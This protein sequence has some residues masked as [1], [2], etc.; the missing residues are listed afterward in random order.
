MRPLTITGN[1]FVIYKA[2]SSS[3]LIFTLD[4]PDTLTCI[5]IVTSNNYTDPSGGPLDGICILG[6]SDV[7]TDGIPNLWIIIK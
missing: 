1:Y 4:Y 5:Q 7:L 3:M 6:P 2:P